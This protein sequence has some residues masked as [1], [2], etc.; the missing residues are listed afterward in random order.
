MGERERE[1]TEN[2]RVVV[3]VRPFNETER[4]RGDRWILRV[5]FI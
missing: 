4:N 5:S 3:R 2:I 1:G